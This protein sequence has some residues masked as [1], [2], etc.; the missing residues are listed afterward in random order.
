[1][2]RRE[3]SIFLIVGSLTVGVD[4]LSY[5]FLAHVLNYNLAKGCGFIIGTI[6][7]YLANRYWTFKHTSAAANT[8]IPRFVLLYGLTLAINIAANHLV[9]IFLPQ[10]QGIFLLAFLVATGIS[11]T[12]NFV[13]MKFF[14]FRNH[15]LQRATL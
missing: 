10:L 8:S 4:Y 7:A 15:S 2:I 12:L 14:V 9:L 13:G 1:M 6:F 11:A 5:H 3:L